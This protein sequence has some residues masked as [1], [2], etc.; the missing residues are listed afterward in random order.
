MT[1]KALL[2]SNNFQ[3]TIVQTTQDW[4]LCIPRICD[5]IF[6]AFLFICKKEKKII[7]KPI[8]GNYL[9]QCVKI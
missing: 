8:R 9:R 5:T 2:L 4:T 7:T 1:N 3:K 6:C